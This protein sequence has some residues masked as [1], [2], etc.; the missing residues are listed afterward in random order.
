MIANAPPNQLLVFMKT[1]AGKH[2]V[3][4]VNGGVINARK[5]LLSTVPKSFEEISPLTFNVS[6]CLFN[7]WPNN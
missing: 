3:T 6:K 4:G 7:Y 5:R 2:A 1:L